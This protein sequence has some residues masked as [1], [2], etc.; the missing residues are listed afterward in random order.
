MDNCIFDEHS[1]SDRTE[2]E[3]RKKNRNIIKMQRMNNKTMMHIET[4]DLK[5]NCDLNWT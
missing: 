4:N 5:R 3:E 1:G 2:K